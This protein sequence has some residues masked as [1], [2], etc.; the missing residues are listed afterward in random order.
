MDE[1]GNLYGTT[2]AGGNCCGADIFGWGAGGVFELT[3]TSGV[4]SEEVLHYSLLKSELHRR[5]RT[6][7]RPFARLRRHSL[8]HHYIRRFVFFSCY[9]LGCGTSLRARLQER[10][11]SVPTHWHRWRPDYQQLD[12][13]CERQFLRHNPAGWSFRRWHRIQA[14]AYSRGWLDVHR[15]L[16]LPRRFCGGRLFCHRCRL[17]QGWQSIRYGLGPARRQLRGLGVWSGL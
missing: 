13:R 6:L 17:R 14:V 15:A 16:Q 12:F 4:W 11:A 7:Q 9:N 3:I 2:A 5:E 1:V 10:R 8:W